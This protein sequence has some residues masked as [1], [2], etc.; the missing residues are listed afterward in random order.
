MVFRLVN[1][2][3]N[4][5]SFVKE[6]GTIKEKARFNGYDDNMISKLA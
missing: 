5:T 2:P 4:W 1:I 3:F 6:L